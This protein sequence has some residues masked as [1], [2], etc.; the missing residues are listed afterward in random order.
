[1]KKIYNFILRAFTEFKI[2][3]ELSKLP[4]IVELYEKKI[5]FLK[6]LK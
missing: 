3:W 5:Y 2:G 1:M 4:K 6:L